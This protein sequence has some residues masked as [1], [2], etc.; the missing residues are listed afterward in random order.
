MFGRRLCSKNLPCALLIQLEAFL[1]TR[2]MYQVIHVRVVR[3][4]KR[5]SCNVVSACPMQRSDDL[6]HS[7][8]VGC[9]VTSKRHQL[10]KILKVGILVLLLCGF[11]LGAGDGSHRIGDH[12]IDHDLSPVQEERQDCL[13]VN[14]S[15]IR[16][17]KQEVMQVPCLV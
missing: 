17:V 9:L 7:R 3:V 14:R 2:A 12:V 10:F 8:L 11:P 4:I 15:I 6:L 1:V 5:K 16:I 13:P